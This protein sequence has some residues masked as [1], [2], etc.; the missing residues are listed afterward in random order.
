MRR[1]INICL[2]DVKH[3]ADRLLE[4]QAIIFLLLR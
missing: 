3:L 1:T 4:K 2:D